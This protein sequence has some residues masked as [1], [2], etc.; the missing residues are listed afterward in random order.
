MVKSYLAGFHRQDALH[1]EYWVRPVYGRLGQDDRW[2]QTTGK[3]CFDPFEAKVMKVLDENEESVE[4]G[5]LG[6]S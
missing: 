5:T 2:P 1:F 3:R 6:V 4:W